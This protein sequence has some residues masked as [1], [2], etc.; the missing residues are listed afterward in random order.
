MAAL[1]RDSDAHGHLPHLVA[2]PGV[3]RDGQGLDPVVGQ[4]DPT[5]DLVPC[6]HRLG[7]SR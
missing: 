4:V 7:L 6:A 5:A 3:N 2:T 1:V